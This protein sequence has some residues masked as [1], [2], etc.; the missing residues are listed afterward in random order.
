MPG[1][2]FALGENPKRPNSQAAPRRYPTTRPG[3]EFVI[4]DAF[5]RKSAIK[6]VFV[7]GRMVKVD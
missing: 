2:K 1:I 4:R 3:V 7:N 5:D 6:H